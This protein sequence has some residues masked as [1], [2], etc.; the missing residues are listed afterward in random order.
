MLPEVRAK[1]S[2]EEREEDILEDAEAL[3]E[4]VEE[5]TLVRIPVQS[6][7]KSQRTHQEVDDPMNME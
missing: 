1:L 5:A 2:L 4:V 6:R 3:G 7:R